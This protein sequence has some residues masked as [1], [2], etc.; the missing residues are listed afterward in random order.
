MCSF[1]AA[2]GFGTGDAAVAGFGV[3]DAVATGFGV[4]DAV[5]WELDDCEV[6]RSLQPRRTI[7]NAR[8]IG[9]IDFRRI[10]VQFGLLV[11]ALVLMEKASF[12]R[13]MMPFKR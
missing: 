8:Q 11:G 5:G 3:G 2:T 13:E 12:K 9:A 1:G 7:N 6:C 4:G 10:M